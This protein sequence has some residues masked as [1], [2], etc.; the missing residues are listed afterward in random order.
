MSRSDVARLLLDQNLSPRLVRLLQDAY[1]HSAHVSSLGLDRAP[2]AVVWK[3]AL[4]GGF[5][6][7][8]KDADFP[9][10]AAVRGTPPRVL[11]LRHGNASTQDTEALLRASAGT[12][13]AFIV[14]PG[15][16]VLRLG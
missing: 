4:D 1:P 14:D 2:D 16:S 10:M 5:V 15:A 9:E 6:L 8:S 13:E 12:V 11:W 7:V 3:A